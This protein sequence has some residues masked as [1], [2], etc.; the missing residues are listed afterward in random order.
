MSKIPLMED[1]YSL[2]GEGYHTGR[3]AYFIRLAGCDV[4]CVWCDVKESWDK[5]AHPEV[6]IQEIVNRVLASGTD[7]VVITGGEPAMYDLKDLTA[8]L[9]EHQIEIAIETSGA[10]KL[11][12]EIDWVCLSPKKFKQP[13]DEIYPLAQELKMIIFNK[14]D[15]QWAEELR[16]KV[17][18]DCKLYLQAEWDKLNQMLPLMIDYVKKNNNWKISL[19]THKFMDIP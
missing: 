11:T 19:Q 13:L 3:P 8:A 1:F 4:G 18:T 9:K 15:F 16:E 14:H 7:F 6:E 2:Q 5:N 12:G 17:A 10:Y